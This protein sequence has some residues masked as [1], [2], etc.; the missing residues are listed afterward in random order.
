MTKPV[1]EL[2]GDRIH[3]L[4]SF[5]DEVS[6]SLMGGTYRTR[7]LDGFNDILRGGFGTPEGGFVLLWLDSETSRAALGTPET[8]RYLERKVHTCHPAN[9]P[10]IQ[11]ELAKAR[12]GEEPSLFDTLVEL[13]RDHGAGGTE[14][15]DG[16]DL[17]LR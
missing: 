16:V 8:V 15:E 4:E 14:E 5:W 11:E 17:E 1:I 10:S 6:R 12:R 2:R 9:V 3:D 7:T 13:I